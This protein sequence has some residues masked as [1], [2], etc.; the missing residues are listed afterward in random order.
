MLVGMN[1]KTQESLEVK[2]LVI[3]GRSRYCLGVD[4]KT[5]VPFFS[6]TQD[7]YHCF[8]AALRM[9]LAHFFPNTTYGW[10]E[11]DRVTA[12]TANYTWP[13]AGLLYCVSLGLDVVVI[14]DFDHKR[15]VKEG[16]NYLLE[17]SGK[18]VADGQQ[19]NSNLRQEIALMHNLDGPVQ[20]RKQIPSRKD[21]RDILASGGLAICNVNSCALVEQPGYSGHF[22]VVIGEQAQ[23]IRLHDPGLPPRED[24]IVS[25]GRFD[26]AWSYPDKKARDIMAFSLPARGTT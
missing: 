9:V 7:N 3:F 18:E 5:R 19:R 15:F 25:W 16:F 13:T 8:Q 2:V 1:E 11:L 21:L 22:V 10:D 20:I 23:G 26:R 12:H 14:S 24:V 6:N 17:W 4:Q